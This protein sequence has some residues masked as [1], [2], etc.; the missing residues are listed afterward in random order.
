[1]SANNDTL[2]RQ[3]G[4]MQDYIESR[5]YKNPAVSKATVGWHLSHNL[6]VIS[7]VIDALK[8][9]DPEDY[10]STFS[11]KKTM[12]FLTGRIPRGVAKSPKV[13]LPPDVIEKKDLIFQLE[14]TRQNLLDFDS[15]PKNANF[16]HPYFSKLNK[17]ETKKFLEIHT[18]HHLKIIKDIL[19]VRNN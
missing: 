10:K 1:M 12:V 17:K 11:L 6:K 5:D 2:L 8:A 7:N 18:R 4:E 14:K 19:T 13:V 9:S 16:Q 3:L 15:L